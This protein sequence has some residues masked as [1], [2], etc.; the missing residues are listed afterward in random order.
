MSK[1]GA[2]GDFPTL[3]NLFSKL[4][5]IEGRSSSSE[6]SKAPEA[7]DMV[8]NGEGRMKTNATRSGHVNPVN[9]TS[10]NFRDCPLTLHRARRPMLTLGIKPLVFIIF[11]LL[12]M[13][14]LLKCP[15]CPQK[16]ND[17]R[18]LSVHQRSCT[19][20]KALSTKSA[21]AKRKLNTKNDENSKLQ[22]MA[23]DLTE[24][25]LA[26]RDEL[27]EIV[28]EGEFEVDEELVSKINC[29]DLSR[30]VIFFISQLP[31][32]QTPPPEL[33][34]SGLPNRTRR[35]P[36]RYR[37]EPPPAP[38]IVLPEQLEDVPI[39]CNSQESFQDNIEDTPP[40]ITKSNSY[41]VFRSYPSGRPSFTPDELFTLNGVSDSPNFPPDA[42]ASQAR[43]WWSSLSFTKDF[44]APFRNASIFRIL[45]WHYNGSNLK[46]LSQLNTLVEDVIL[47]PDFKQEDFV[48]FSASREAERLDN[49]AEN[50]ESPF[51]PKDG[52]I[53]TSVSISV[54]ADNVK[55]PSVDA[56]PKYE[57]SGLFYRPLVETIK[58]SFQE[59]SAEHFN[60]FPF[61]E[62]W[63]RET[64]ASGKKE[65]LYSEVYTAETFIEEHKRIQAQPREPGCNLETVVVAIMCYS[66]SMHLTSF[67]NAALWPIYEW[68]GNQSKYPRGKPTSFAAQHVAYIPKVSW[69][70]KRSFEIPS[71]HN[72]SAG[73]CI[74]RLVR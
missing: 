60:L 46:S 8:V 57:V 51:S 5:K 11:L 27:R 18:G 65:R 47:Q 38:P 1:K 42:H 50:P 12:C 20:Y 36:A 45:N 25:D 16:F 56:A 44:F 23:T 64:D 68:F 37:D 43:P 31:K 14:A 69:V 55:H 58:S 72:C 15:A 3:I 33:R 49:Y 30:R 35:L 62:Y 73:R 29:Q 17:N 61:E 2:Y 74:S 34:P 54:P 40:Y 59:P 22:K 66:D 26:Q 70:I 39:S 67:G 28:N 4:L 10:P 53:E 41:G 7:S 6:A 24:E 71:D 19:A 52:W 48:G 32:S 21:G 13:P 63:V 9:Q